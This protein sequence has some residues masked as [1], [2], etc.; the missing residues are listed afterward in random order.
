VLIVEDVEDDALLLVRELERAGYQLSYERV[1]TQEAMRAALARQ[2]WDVVF[3]DYKMPGFSVEGALG[4]LGESGLDLPFIIVSGTIG[5]ETAITAL[6]AGA[7]DF[8]LKG[9]Y[10]RLIPALERELSVAEVRRE[11]RQAEALLR[12]QGAVL[13]AAAN[14][15]VI[16]DRDGVITWVN[17]ACTRLTGYTAEEVV[18][19]NPRLFKSGGHDLTFYQ[20]LWATIRAGQVWHGEV[21]NRRKDGG[22]YVLEQTITPLLDGRGTITHFIAIQH[23]ITER[24]R[25]EDA[26]RVKDEELRMM[27]QQLWHA[28]KLATMGE[29]A[30]SVAHELNNPLATVSLRAEALLAQTPPRAPMRHALEVISQETDRMGKLVADLL[31]FSRRSG[32]QRSTVDV[33]DEVDKTLE[34]IQYH[35]RRRN[36]NVVRTFAPDVPVVLADRQQLRQV[37]LNLFINASDAMPQGGA[38]TIHIATGALNGG[39]TAVV[40]EVADTGDGIPA[41]VL[42]RIWEPFYTTK[43]E[44]K[45]TGLGL[46]ICRRIVEDHRGTITITSVVGQGTAVRVALPVSVWEAPSA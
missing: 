20:N 24:K 15:I 44:G 46:A 41:E 45:G 39:E 36:V 6:K 34:L 3:S 37:L 10:A 18:G 17:P 9:N 14:A 21:T 29:L 43:P 5:E 7:H 28:T 30:A 40:T 35:L 31:Q 16:T 1:D 32:Q 27:S 2:K 23:D 4:L 42:P 8:L 26:L 12:L 22:L 38:L 13:N 19:Q 11:R 33:R 25:A